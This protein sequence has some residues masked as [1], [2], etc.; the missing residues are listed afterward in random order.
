MT[1]SPTTIKNLTAISDRLFSQLIEMEKNNTVLE[2]CPAFSKVLR[3]AVIVTKMISQSSLG[4]KHILDVQSK[5]IKRSGKSKEADKLSDSLQHVREVLLDLIE[6]QSNKLM[7][8]DKLMQNHQVSFDSSEVDALFS[9]SKT[10]I[11]SYERDTGNVINSIV[12]LS[13]YSDAPIFHVLRY[14]AELNAHGKTSLKKRFK[15]MLR[16]YMNSER[17]E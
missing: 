11:R 9:M 16:R 12:H 8:L 10:Q 7:F 4:L 13:R 2:R 14:G 5:V 3:Q 15:R 6:S 1:S 17:K